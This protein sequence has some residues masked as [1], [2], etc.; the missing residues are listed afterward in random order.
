M[1]TDACAGADIFMT[2]NALDVYVGYLRRK[3]EAG[4]ETAAA[5][6]GPRHRLHALELTCRSA[7]G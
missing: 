6:D 7:A 5:P 1:T 2:S 3:T 4:G